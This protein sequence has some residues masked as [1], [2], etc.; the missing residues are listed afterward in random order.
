VGRSPPA[1][2]RDLRWWRYRRRPRRRTGGLGTPGVR[3]CSTPAGRGLAAIATVL[4]VTVRASVCTCRK[5]PFPLQRLHS[6]GP[7]RASL[8]VSREEA[9]ASA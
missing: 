2:V 4:S 7:C 1:A 6:C 3:P 9:W 8:P 5:R